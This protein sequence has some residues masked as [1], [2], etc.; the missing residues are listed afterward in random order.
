MKFY[1]GKCSVVGMGFNNN[2]DIYD[3]GARTCPGKGRANY[4]SGNNLLLAQT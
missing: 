1:V 3:L 4:R 2:R